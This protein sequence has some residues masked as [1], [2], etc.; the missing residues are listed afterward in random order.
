MTSVANV[1]AVVGA[2]NNPD[3]ISYQALGRLLQKN[4]VA[5]PV[6]PRGG[7]ILGQKVVPSLAAIS[8]SVDTVTMYINP[9]HQ[10]TVLE[11]II[12]LKPRRVIFNPGSE[13][14]SAYKRLQQAGIAV[15]E[16]CTLVL[17]STRQ[18]DLPV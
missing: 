12:A 1:V 18:F 7:E 14:P 16:A 10:T 5:V 8:E 9:D 11:E 3:R 6:N 15:Q 2:S 4:Y 17:L 13:N